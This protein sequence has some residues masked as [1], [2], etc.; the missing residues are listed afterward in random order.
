MYNKQGKKI[1]NLIGHTGDV[2][3]IAIDGDRLVSGGGD[4]RMMVWDLKNLKN[5]IMMKYL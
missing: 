5:E 3:S 4:Q 2:W 1:A